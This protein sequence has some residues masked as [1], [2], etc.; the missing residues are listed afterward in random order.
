LGP[1]R[2]ILDIFTHVNTYHEFDDEIPH[3]EGGVPILNQSLEFPFEVPSSPHEED[4]STSSEQGVNL[5][6]VIERIERLKLDGNPIPS[7]SVDKLRRSQKGPSKWLLKTLEIV[8]PDE[9]GKTGTRSSTRK[10]RGD[11]YN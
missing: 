2:N 11:V 7:Q 5:D 10:D 9:V 6:D 8:C 1:P 3:I 4:P